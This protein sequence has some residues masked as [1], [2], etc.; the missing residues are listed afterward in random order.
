MISITDGQIYLEP[1]LFFAG[2]RPAVNVGI[3]VS[4]VGGNAQ[5]KAMK[6]VAGTLRLE[7]A[8]FRELEAFAQL[9][10][11]LDA[12][13]QA[14]LD[15][16]YLLVELLKQGQYKPVAVADQVV[17]I[18]A[19]TRGMMDGLPIAEVSAFEEQLLKEI[20]DAHPEIVEEIRT[21]GALSDELDEKLTA[22]CKSFREHHDREKE[23]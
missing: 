15:R 21:T 6:K 22:A 17:T 3:S 7:L 20:H 9:G 13:T 18:F 14:A 23:A 16:G 8:Q 10:T 19:A 5:I 2:V 4:R 12:S 11:D 1:D